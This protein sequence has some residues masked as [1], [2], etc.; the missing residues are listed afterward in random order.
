MN[1][2]FHSAGHNSQKPYIIVITCFHLTIFYVIMSRSFLL[3]VRISR[4]FPV[5]R[6]FRT[7]SFRDIIGCVFIVVLSLRTLIIYTY[8]F[9]NFFSCCLMDECCSSAVWCHVTYQWSRIL[10]TYSSWHAHLIIL[11]L[12]F[13]Y[14][15]SHIS[16]SHVDS[17]R[18]WIVMRYRIAFSLILVCLVT[19]SEGNK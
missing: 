17:Q 11:I 13:L 15:W 4:R 14:F 16:I 1:D 8:L 12:F 7:F 2:L 10:Y 3:P 19:S 9:I 6:L 5:E 18:L